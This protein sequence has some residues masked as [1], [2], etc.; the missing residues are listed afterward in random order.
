MNACRDPGHDERRYAHCW[1]R[2]QR[3]PKRRKRP[4]PTPSGEGSLHANQAVVLCSSDGRLECRACTQR[5]LTVLAAKAGACRDIV[6]QLL[7]DSLGRHNN[8][9]VLLLPAV[10]MKQYLAINVY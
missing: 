1:L 4:S 10:F 2:K 6:L 3:F 7:C 9:I 5:L 8:M